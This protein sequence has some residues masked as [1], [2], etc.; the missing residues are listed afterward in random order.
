M[1]KRPRSAVAAI[2]GFGIGVAL[3]SVATTAAI[4][5]IAPEPDSLRVSISDAA[6]ALRGETRGFERS[7]G[8]EPDGRRAAL[9]EAVLADQ[10]R[11]PVG[12]VRII[13][14]GPDTPLSRAMTSGGP[15]TA[16]TKLPV[17]VVRRT[18][19]RSS[20]GPTSVGDAQ[21]LRRSS[22]PRMF[23]LLRN[24]SLP[25]RIGLATVPINAFVASVRQA[26]GRWLTV[27]PYQPWLSGWRL[28]VIAA[29][30]VSLLL[31]LPLAWLFA[32]R[33]TRPFRALA[34]AVDA[35]DATIPI[36]GPRELREAASAIATMRARLADETAE[37][38]RMLTAIAHDL[39][40]PLTSLRLRIESADE[41]QRSRMVADVERMQGMIGE[42]LGFARDVALQ[43]QSV[44][45]RPL[46]AQI[47]ADMD[48]G[49]GIVTLAPGD[50]GWIEAAE[51]A[52]RRAIENLVRNAI[53]HAGGGRVEIVRK[54]D[55]VVL[56]VSDAGPG[57]APVD[58]AR[59]L[60]PFERGEASRNRETGGAGL[61]LSIV[62]DF[63]DKHRGSLVIR[64]RNEG[65]LVVE[66]ALPS[67]R[68][69]E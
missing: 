24:P 53:D 27:K 1:T 15:A 25:V 55:D 40:T 2:G 21:I 3:L 13:M 11:R 6:M 28:R 12:D 60:R 66:L 37:R 20:D 16:N 46:V 14:S 64:N 58:R 61:G 65:G 38:L 56:T 7:I 5:L 52:L 49:R 29:V 18:I 50:D 44:A 30:L 31:I 26:D 35:G 8:P 34:Q 4:V 9:F 10:V 63:A 62:Q 33:L 59:L 36:E 32:R 41:P 48:A 19:N 68:P 47:V 23:D 42:V 45:V 57:I 67:L 54:G 22:D 51:S 17:F 43:R 39:R 69:S